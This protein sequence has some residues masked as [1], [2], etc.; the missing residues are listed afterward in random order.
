MK[1]GHA[2]R[3]HILAMGHV[4]LSSTP[5]VGINGN[6]LWLASA[7]W[8]SACFNG[9]A[10]KANLGW[11]SPFEA[12][13]GRKSP[14]TVVPFLQ[15]GMMRVKRATKADVPSARRFYLNGANNPNPDKADSSN[16]VTLSNNVLLPFVQQGGRALVLDRVS[17][18]TSSASAIKKQVGTVSIIS[19]SLLPLLSA[20]CRIAFALA[21]QQTTPVGALGGRR[22]SSIRENEPWPVQLGGKTHSEG[23]VGMSVMLPT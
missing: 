8:T 7:L 13:F 14:L 16:G 5:D 19:L 17:A 18:V 4:D 11:M 20:T 23:D 15:E 22:R 10:T 3:R 21:I 12:F 6:R 9:S 2:A 1:G